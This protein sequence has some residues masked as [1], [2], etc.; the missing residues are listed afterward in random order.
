M[1]DCDIALRTTEGK[2]GRERQMKSYNLIS[3][4]LKKIRPYTETKKCNEEKI[5]ITT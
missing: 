1:K 5:K 2:W 3:P 4:A